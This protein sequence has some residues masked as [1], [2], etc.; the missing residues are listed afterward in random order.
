MIYLDNGATTFP[1]PPNVIRAVNQALTEYGANPGRGGHKMS[2][3]AAEVV[4][5]CRKNAAL[6]FGIDNPENVIITKNCTESLNIVIK[7]L[8]KKNDH[9]VISSLEH[10]AVLR[11][12]EAMRKRGVD[13]T[14]AQAVPYDDEQTINNFRSAINE[15]TK[16]V[17]CTQAS[18][19]F[20]VRM[21]IERIAA[22]CKIH[23]VL[24]CADGAQGAGVINLDL[25]NTDIDFYCTAG[26]KGLYGPMGTGLLIINSDVHPESLIEGGTGTD[27]ANKTQPLTLPDRYESG[28]LNL[29]GVAGLCEGISFV[30]SKT[31][32]RIEAYEMKLAR[33][34]YMG[35]KKLKK[36]NLYTKIPDSSYSVP[37]IS[38]NIDGMDCETAADILGRK[39]G[40]AVRSGL[41]CA[42]LAH[43]SFGTEQ[44]TIRVVVSAFT[45]Q[46][47][48][49]SFLW[50][51]KN[52][53]QNKP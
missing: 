11:P 27:S 10:N 6:L 22:M 28:T 13:Y 25:K 19:V 12:L 4:Y 23:G 37:V 47:Q 40:I 36:V 2:I 42:P 29:P 50:A 21:P 41:H 51:V 46:K 35:L 14:I 49:Q 16:L 53:T 39:Y 15:R 32:E 33:H 45:N 20:G 9:V 5:N 43:N 52:M 38:F 34:L 17:I 3:K 31:P 26:H 24:F 1:K 30:R 8:L 44:G 18:N 7:G 48:I